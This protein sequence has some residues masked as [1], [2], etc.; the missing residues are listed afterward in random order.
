[1]TES[2]PH[3]V[4]G[5]GQVGLVLAAR[6]AAQGGRVRVVSRHRLAAP[7]VGVDWWGVHATDPEAA[8][9]APAATW[10]PIR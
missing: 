8:P 3:V 1:M 9:V 7:A 10:P 4:F 6:L 5:T 2:P